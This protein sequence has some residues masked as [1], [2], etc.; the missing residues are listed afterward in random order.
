MV[1]IVID[2]FKSKSMKKIVLLIAIT[3]IAKANF[4]QDD[5]KKFRFGLKASPN[6]SW[7]QPETKDFKSEGA[8]INFSYGLITEFGFSPNYSFVTGLEVT[9]L[10]G[11]LSFP[12]FTNYFVDDKRGDTT[13]L[14]YLKERDYTVQYVDLPL[15]L[16]MKTKEIGYMT[17]FGQ[18]GFNTSFRTK[19]IADDKVKAYLTGL[20]SELRDIKINDDMN[21]FRVGLNVGAGAE[22]NISGNT[23]MFFNLNYSNGFTNALKKESKT[24]RNKDGSP[25]KQKAASKYISLTVGIFF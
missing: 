6:I 20:E 9:T 13:Q 24:L 11:S 1:N 16:K 19:A 4:A 25:L 3:L 22:Y 23:S 7:F 2:N 17:Y 10:G 21:L 18:F 15:L 12:E 14:V 5:F 8:K